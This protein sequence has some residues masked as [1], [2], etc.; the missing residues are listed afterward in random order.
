VWTGLIWLK[1][2]PV[3]GFCKQNNEPLIF[4]KGG[5]VS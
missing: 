4:I 3:A 5:E 1:I 2:G